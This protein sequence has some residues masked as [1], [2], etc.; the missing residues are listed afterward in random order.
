MQTGAFDLCTVLCAVVNR[1]YCAVRCCAVRCGG[2][3]LG[4][5]GP[6]VQCNGTDGFQIRHLYHDEIGRLIRAAVTPPLSL[7]LQ[8]TL[9]ST[10]VDT[11][12]SH[13]RDRQ[14]THQHDSVGC[15]DPKVKNRNRNRGAR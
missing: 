7:D 9:A 5:Q 8:C 12:E 15:N 1:R 11:S 14:H 2:T 4:S 13:K 6:R 10:W 3:R